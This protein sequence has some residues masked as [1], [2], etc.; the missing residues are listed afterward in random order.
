MADS[1]S[2]LELGT[3]TP[4]L[5]I[6]DVTQKP[7]MIESKGQPLGTF[8]SSFWY[9]YCEE[10]DDKAEIVIETDTP[11]ICNLPSLGI[12]MMLHLQWG[13]IFPQNEKKC[14]PV[15]KVVIR[16][17]EESYSARGIK[18]T[19]KCTD[20]FSLLK[21]SPADLENQLFGQWVKNNVEGKFTLEII[22]Y[23]KNHQ[24]KVIN[25]E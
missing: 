24:I 5:A 14:G 18:I 11:D 9:E 25:N 3:A 12:Q 8:V 16:D 10:D 17:V 19:L 4:Y 15:R 20:A 22:N 6:F 2:I 1:T 21:Q 13:Y 23:N 7:I